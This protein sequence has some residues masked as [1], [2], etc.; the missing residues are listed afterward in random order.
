MSAEAGVRARVARLLALAL[1]CAAPAAAQQATTYDLVIA[2]GRVIDPETRLDAVR[3][4]GISGGTIRA[5][6]A[7]PLAGKERIDAR[8]LIVAPGFIDL[9]EHG[10]NPV[11]YRF[12]VR[13]GV[14]TALE[15]EIGV[16]DVDAW[17]AARAAGE[18]VNYG[19]TISH[20]RVRAVIM[21]DPSAFL[22]T[23]EAAHRPATP[24]EDSALMAGIEKGLERGA[25]GVGFGLQYTPAASRAEVLD[26]F[27]L[28]AKYHAPAFVHLRYM[29]LKE[30]TNSLTA[31]QEVL[32]DAAVTG[33]PLHVVHI[34]STGLAATHTLLGMIAGARARGLDVTTEA[35][36]YTAGQTEIASAIFDEGW[37]ELMGI[38][39]DSLEWVKTGERLTAESFA[40]YRAENGSV[41]VHSIPE[42]AMQEVIAAP[43]TIVA[44]DGAL[45]SDS[46]GHPRATGTYSRVLGRF[47]REE[48]KLDWSTALAKM[49]LLPARR[50]EARDP[51]MKRKGRV[52]TGADAD[53]TVFDPA[54]VADRGRY[55][56]P[57]VPSAGI[58]YV[59]VGGVPVVFDG[60]LR[61]V[62]PG[63]AVRA[64]IESKPVSLR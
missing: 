3:D 25:L 8:G 60:Q 57:A 17:Y 37:Q 40:R 33:A 46:T 51:A 48:K 18:P 31:L 27:R 24:A 30:P 1:A 49:T 43:W 54:T 29:G 32:A 22:P 39:Y 12:E 42:P 26:A 45:D 58:R 53:I 9:H 56:N 4:V 35:Y 20:P 6:S 52:Q 5:V 36:P 47:V 19:A 34:H 2:G 15:L 64:P 50:L 7:T 38:S 11:A 63:K 23:G 44:S 10:Q 41:I 62:K 14:T 16:P 61:D 13:D 21:H 55:G 28:A 59:L